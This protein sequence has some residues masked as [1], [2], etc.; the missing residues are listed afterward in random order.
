MRLDLSEG[1]HQ[2][3]LEVIRGHCMRLDLS[4]GIL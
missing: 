4:E 3:S 2:R 1:V